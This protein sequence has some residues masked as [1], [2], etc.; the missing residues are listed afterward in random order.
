VDVLLETAVS[1]NT[2]SSSHVNI[3]LPYFRFRF[4]TAPQFGPLMVFKF[5]NKV[6]NH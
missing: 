2:S 4:V 3:S 6:T 1:N 5:A